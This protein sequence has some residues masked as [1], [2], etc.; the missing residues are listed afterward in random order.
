MTRTSVLIVAACALQVPPPP[1]GEQARFSTKATA[2]IIDVAVTDGER[3]VLGLTKDD[4]VVMDNG[5]RQEIQDL[6]LERLPTDVHITADISGSMR[7]ADRQIIN[8]A[9]A[10][11]GRALSPDDRVSTTVFWTHISQRTPLGPPSA[12]RTVSDAGHDT[13]VLDAM[14]L[15]LVQ[16]EIT[17]RRQFS[18]FMTDGVDTASHFDE[19]T[20]LATAR[21]A[22]GPMTVVLAP[23][24][25]P[26]SID[27]TLR[28]VALQTG[29]EV[30]SLKDRSQL[31]GTFSR[32]LE[33][34]RSSYV[35]RYFPTGVAP[36]GWHSVNVSVKSSRYTV[37]A[38]QGWGSPDSLL[39]EH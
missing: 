29:G 11:V 35:V 20:V 32:A 6:T 21:H 33:N 13:V 39:P 36:G 18:I 23:D 31:R 38:R 5:V 19:A 26:R 37:R 9:I 17:G 22:K 12:I 24:R 16:P 14:L 3:P 1:T 2:V 34:F 7:A 4:F 8:D 27:G 15:A 25:A 30:I 10:Q 28:S